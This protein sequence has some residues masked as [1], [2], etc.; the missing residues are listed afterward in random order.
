MGLA[1][2]GITGL[3]IV[4]DPGGAAERIYQRLGFT[5]TEEQIGFQRIPPGVA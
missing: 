5:G 1:R 2:P 4:A 3:V